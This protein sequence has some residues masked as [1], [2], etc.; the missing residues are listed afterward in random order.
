[1]EEAVGDNLAAGGGVVVE[2]V[3]LEQLVEDDLIDLPHRSDPQDGAGAQD[4]AVRPIG[5]L[6]PPSRPAA[7][8]RRIAQGTIGCGTPGGPWMSLSA[9]KPVVNP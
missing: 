6:A 4:R 7:Y 3:S 5:R 2:V 9:T 8:V 1:M